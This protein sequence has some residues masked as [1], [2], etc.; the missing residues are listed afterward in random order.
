MD[1]WALRRLAAKIL[2]M[3]PAEAWELL[4]KLGNG[5]SPGR[6]EGEIVDPEMGGKFF[7]E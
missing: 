7:D 1:N 2:L 3:G 5:D 6:G 4:Q